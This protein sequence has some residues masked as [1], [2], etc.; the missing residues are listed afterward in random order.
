MKPHLGV[1]N[2][3]YAILAVSAGQIGSGSLAVGRSILRIDR[4]FNAERFEARFDIT[5]PVE[6]EGDDQ[7]A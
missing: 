7:W 2:F 6:R 5:L 4:E 1:P 3:P